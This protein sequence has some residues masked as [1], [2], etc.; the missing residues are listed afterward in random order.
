MPEPARKQEAEVATPPKR[1]GRKPS[2]TLEQAVEIGRTT[3]PG[4]EGHASRRRIEDAVRDKGFTI[5]K[6]LAEK[7]KDILQAELNGHAVAVH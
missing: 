6:D 7:A 5:N 2:A 1:K 3:Q 4:R